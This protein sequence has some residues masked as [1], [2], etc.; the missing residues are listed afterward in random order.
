[1]QPRIPTPV[2]PM[3]DGPQGPRGFCL[4]IILGVAIEVVLAVVASKWLGYL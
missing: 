1:M 3:S 4:V 2:Q